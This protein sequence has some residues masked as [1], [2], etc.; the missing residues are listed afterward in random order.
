MLSLTQ[1][2]MEILFILAIGLTIIA[3]VR[4]VWRLNRFIAARKHA[5]YL[6]GPIMRDLSQ[7]TRAF[8][9]GSDQVR[10]VHRRIPQIAS[11]IAGLIELPEGLYWEFERWVFREGSETV[12]GFG[13]AENLTFAEFVAAFR[14]DV[15]VG[16]IGS[17]IAIAGTALARQGGEISGSVGSGLIVLGLLV[18]FF[19]LLS[20]DRS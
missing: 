4:G 8:K 18:I 13:S 1:Q 3:L 11:E 16:A 5:L 14:G 20:P 2:M 7:E 17:Y 19:T 9:E 15:I 6:L 12:F 10:F